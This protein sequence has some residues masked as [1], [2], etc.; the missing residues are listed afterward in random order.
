VSRRS[1]RPGIR[2]VHEDERITA[3]DKSPALTSVSER[4]DPAA[5]TAIDLLWEEW[6]RA[7]PDAPRP[8]VIHRLDKDTSGLLLFARDREA[9]VSLR[10]QFRARSVEKTYFALT[11]G[12]PEAAEGSI[13]VSIEPD[14]ARP[15]RVRTVRRGGK[16]CRT[17]YRT[18]QVLGPHAWVRLHPRTGRTHQLR[19]SL[20]ELGTPIVGDPWYGDGAPL[21]LSSVKRDYRPGRGE[22]E[23]PLLGR[24]GLHALQLTFD[25]P[26]GGARITVEAPLPKDLRSALRQLERWTRARRA[27]GA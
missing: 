18:E 7:D 8:H 24:L 10:E 12:V 27:P 16:E 14:P 25:H 20:R 6:K 13:E 23:R 11:D 9:Q 17:E 22:P 15:G 19:I 4:W 21:L 1:P 5:P 26:A 3:I 2:I